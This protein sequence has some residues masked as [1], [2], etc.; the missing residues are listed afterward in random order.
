[1]QNMFGIQKSADSGKAFIQSATAQYFAAYS[2]AANNQPR[3]VPA[4]HCA[5]FAEEGYE[6]GRRPVTTLSGDKM[7]CH[8]VKTAPGRVIVT[9]FRHMLARGDSRLPLEKRIQEC[10]CP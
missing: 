5:E 8:F 6:D 2:T 4:G 1:M 10:H 7:E 9:L 3:A